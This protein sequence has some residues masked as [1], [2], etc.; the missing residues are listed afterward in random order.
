MS[1]DEHVFGLDGIREGNNK[2][3]KWLMV[4]AISLISW[5]VYYMI[6][7]WTMPG[8]EVRKEVLNSSITYKNAR[9]EGYVASSKE[10]KEEK[11]DVNVAAAANEKFMA[12]G[13]V[14][15][16]TNCAGCHGVSG[17]GMGPA[18]AALVPKPRNFVQ[19]KMKYGDD[20]ASVNKS[21][22]NGIKGT[23]MPA[24]KDTLS[25]D[26]IKSVV[27]YIKHFKQ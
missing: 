23:A 4:V 12:E 17:D 20:D 1:G 2:F 25:A 5:S 22:E 24:W 16:E 9:E 7:Y 26:Q 11:K 13:K 14:V 21:V 18:A 15:Y 6:T 3:P 8:D 27:V 10:V 19:W